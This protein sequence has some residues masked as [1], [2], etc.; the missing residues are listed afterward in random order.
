VDR[1][2]LNAFASHI[3]SSPSSISTSTSP[4]KLVAFIYMYDT[5]PAFPI[6][7]SWY[8]CCRFEDHLLCSSDIVVRGPQQSHDAILHIISDICH[9]NASKR[10]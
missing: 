2:L 6:K 7:I 9:K 8:R 3:P 1:T 5:N 10:R 4:R